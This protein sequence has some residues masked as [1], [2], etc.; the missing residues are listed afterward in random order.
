[1]PPVNITWSVEKAIRVGGKNLRFVIL[2]DKWSIPAL[3][4]PVALI[5]EECGYEKNLVT[6]IDQMLIIFCYQVIK[7]KHLSLSLAW[8]CS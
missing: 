3:L 2:A 7:I 6:Q 4:T 8:L 5:R 1:M